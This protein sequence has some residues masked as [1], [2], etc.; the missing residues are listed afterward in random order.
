VAF[1]GLAFEFVLEPRYRRSQSLA[2]L[3]RALG[4]E[5][6]NGATQQMVFDENHSL[7][8]GRS[9]AAPHIFRDLIVGGMH[10]C[11]YGYHRQILDS[12]IVA[13]K[14]GRGRRRKP[15][16]NF[17]KT[18]TGR[19]LGEGRVARAVINATMKL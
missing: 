5:D 19:T 13:A 2:E 16:G 7:G 14:T 12:S 15:G 18:V 11:H 17:E 3:N 8:P 6:A 10:D 9:E 4:P 1:F